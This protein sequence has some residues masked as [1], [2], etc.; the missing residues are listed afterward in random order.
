MWILADTQFHHIEGTPF[1]DAISDGFVEVAIRPPALDLFAPALLASVLEVMRTQPD[2]PI[3]FLGDGANVS[4]VDEYDRFL[5]T[6]GSSPWL[7]VIG[8]H[9]GYFIGN[10][11]DEDGVTKNWKSSCA[12]GPQ[13]RALLDRLAAWE[14]SRFGTPKNKTYANYNAM[15][16]ATA[17]ALYLVGL[18]RR[19]LITFDPLRNCLP[20]QSDGCW[21]RQA[22]DYWH[23]TTN[24]EL[25]LRNAKLPVK[26]EAVV[27]SADVG[28][29]DDEWDAYLLQDALIPSRKTHVILVDTSDYESRPTSH[30]KTATARCWVNGRCNV[31]GT[32]GNV[33]QAQV[34]TIMSWIDGAQNSGED[35]FLMGHHNWDSLSDQT[36]GRLKKAENSMSFITYVSGHEHD[37]TSKV[38]AEGAREDWEVNVASVTDYPQQFA[39]IAYEPTIDQNVKATR[40]EVTAHDVAS[41]QPA[42][43][44]CEIDYSPNEQ[45]CYFGDDYHRQVREITKLTIERLLKEPALIGGG[46]DRKCLEAKYKKLDSLKISEVTQFVRDT[47]M[48]SDWVKGQAFACAVQA[49]RIER[50]YRCGKSFLANRV[51]R[52][53]SGK[54]TAADIEKTPVDAGT[55]ITK[56]TG[57]YTVHRGPQW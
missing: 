10:N 14:T 23:F 5:T 2:R 55:A 36:I 42:S 40:L 25:P 32:I 52:I 44:K 38:K 18:Q 17:V 45:T 19:G 30:I 8:N 47:L 29:G 39:A 34:G 35:F 37:P 48:Q 51:A 31:P 4:C 12:D 53:K 33:A 26:L 16:K 43:A 28:E 3:F 1:Y 56:D 49:A 41:T 46:C 24:F 20:K 57:V 13:N 9:D 21:S 50:Q 11:V 6:M 7:G 22:D 27:S 15:S 54:L